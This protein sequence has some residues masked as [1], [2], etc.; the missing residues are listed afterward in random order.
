MHPN[1]PCGNYPYPG[2]SK[3]SPGQYV[4]G[5]PQA[6]PPSAGML[7]Q[8]EVENTVSGGVK[9]YGVPGGIYGMG[10][11]GVQPAPGQMVN[12]NMQSVHCHSTGLGQSNP[13]HPSQFGKTGYGTPFNASLGNGVGPP[14]HQHMVPYPAPPY[15]GHTPTAH[16]MHHYSQR[17]MMSPV[18]HSTSGS[19]M[20]DHGSMRP[21]SQ[22]FYRGGPVGYESEGPVGPG[23]GSG[24]SQWVNMQGMFGGRVVEAQHSENIPVDMPPVT[25]P[26][27]SE[28][29]RMRSAPAFEPAMAKDRLS[30]SPISSS[31]YTSAESKSGDL[32]IAAKQTDQP[33]IENDFSMALS[34]GVILCLSIV[35]FLCFSI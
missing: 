1:Q 24:R 2:P 12:A 34:L 5:H 6:V 14:H 26:A 17:P 31:D 22:A 10:K 19:N 16:Q 29:Q 28:I 35:I 13:P 20:V 9:G 27:A 8:M 11:M 30:A 4:Q 21:T 15:G 33:K 7:H 25:I 18:P 32:A 23:N 3:V